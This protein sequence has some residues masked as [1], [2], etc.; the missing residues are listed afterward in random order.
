[1][2]AAVQFVREGLQDAAV[3]VPDQPTIEAVTAFLVALREARARL[4]RFLV[5]PPKGYRLEEAMAAPGA[6]EEA[7][8]VLEEVV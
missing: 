3:S 4:L 1:V 2:P 8:A 6:L 5:D 7:V